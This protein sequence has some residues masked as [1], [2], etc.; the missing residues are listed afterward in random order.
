[1]EKDRFKN[2]LEIDDFIEQIKDE[3]YLHR[4]TYLRHQ[5]YAVLKKLDDV[6]HEY[7][8][9]KIFEHNNLYNLFFDILAEFSYRKPSV[10][11]KEELIC[12]PKILKDEYGGYKL[13]K[14]W[15]V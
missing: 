13:L 6:D 11:G 1:M 5:V 15:E 7:F 12:K 8:V 14:L 4:P 10:D 3:F 9:Q 2:K